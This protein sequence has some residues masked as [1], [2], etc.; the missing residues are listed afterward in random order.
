[1]T[2]VAD[3]SFK[4]FQSLDRC[5]QVHVNGGRVETKGQP[6]VKNAIQREKARERK[7]WMCWLYG[8]TVLEKNH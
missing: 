6:E 8:I 5:S 3:L 1:M 7:G 2:V 4:I